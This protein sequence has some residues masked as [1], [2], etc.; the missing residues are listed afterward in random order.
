[1]TQVTSPPV[2]VPDSIEPLL[3]YRYWRVTD[4]GQ[5]ES[6]TASGHYWPGQQAMTAYC[7]DTRKIWRDGRKVTL[8]R[9]H[10]PDHVPHRDCTCGLYAYEQTRMARWGLMADYMGR[11]MAIGHVHLWGRVISDDEGHKATHAYPRSIILMDPRR[12]HLIP[13][14]QA[15]YLVP[16]RAWE[17]W[18]VSDWMVQSG[19]ELSPLVP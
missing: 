17:S 5:L 10:N 11:D 16:V 8:K 12:G 6:P 9:E 4:D 19:A 1:M 15:R 7:A 18:D 13:V 14:L 3:A 2:A